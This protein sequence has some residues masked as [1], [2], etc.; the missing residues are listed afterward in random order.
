MCHQTHEV[1]ADPCNFRYQE[2]WEGGRGAIVVNG[3]EVA[4]AGNLRL[5]ATS[6]LRNNCNWVNQITEA[7]LEGQLQA[8]P[9]SALGQ[10]L[11]EEYSRRYR[12]TNFH[13]YFT[14]TARYP[15]LRIREQ[16]VSPGLHNKYHFDAV[17]A[18]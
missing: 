4:F 9:G 18:R 6:Q 3:E 12:D 13:V 1:N 2:V 16:T 15:D 10:A 5:V 8:V 14:P 17:L 7:V 11:V